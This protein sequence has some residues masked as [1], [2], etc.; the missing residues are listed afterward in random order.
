[1]SKYPWFPMFF[2]ISE[3]NVL[4][5]GAGEVAGRRA[6]TLTQF[7]AHV[8]VIGPRVGQAVESEVTAGRVTIYRRA[9][10]MDDLDGRDM[11]LAATDDEALNAAI[12]AACRARGIPVNAS[13]DRTLCDFYFPGAV[14]D[15][16]VAVGITAS[17]R[18]HKRAREVTRRIRNVL[19]WGEDE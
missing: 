4:V 11:V 1:M 8:D 12:V 15:G 9:F 16:D 19:R 14:V 2:D 10:T 17:G 6:A 18:D 5:V 13:S 3:K 7:C